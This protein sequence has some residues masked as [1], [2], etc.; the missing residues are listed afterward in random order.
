MNTN[1]ILGFIFLFLGVGIISWTVYNSYN[2]FTAKTIPPEIFKTTESALPVSQKDKTVGLQQEVEKMLQEQLKG[3]LPAD[4]LPKILNLM[5]WSIGAGVLIFGG[6]H[7]SGIGIK[8]LAK[9]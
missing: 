3:M 2:I 4:F 5:A 6:S 8:L 7:I 9:N 1:K